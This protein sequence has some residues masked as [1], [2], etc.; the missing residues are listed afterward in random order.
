MV[1]SRQRIFMRGIK[2]DCDL[3]LRTQRNVV[4]LAADAR[5]V[6]RDRGS[7][8]SGMAS[9]PVQSNAGTTVADALDPQIRRFVDELA[10]A[11]ARYPAAD[12]L[13]IPEMRRIAEEIRA[14]WRQGGPAMASTREHLVPTAQGDVRVRIYSPASGAPALPALIYL[15]GGGW[16]MFS[17]NTHDRVMRELAARAG[18]VVVGVDYAL[19]PEAKF[20]FALRQIE[21][22]ARWLAANGGAWSIDT[23]RIAIGGDSAGANLAVATAL[24]L[25]DNGAP[26]LLRGLL[27]HYGCFTNESSE[28]AITGFG[29]PGNLLTSSEMAAFWTNYLANPDDAR[30]PLAAPLRAHLQ[31]LPPA[32]LISAQCD[33]LAEQSIAFAERLRAAGVAVAHNEYPGATHSFL[34]AVSIAAVA[35]RA[36]SDGAAWLCERLGPAA[37]A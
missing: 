5:I 25:R 18:V 32:L 6:R 9:G 4:Q 28:Q 15:H 12:T 36:L 30:D 31:G 13:T 10:Q 1:S 26:D 21:G 34:E 17:L 3:I 27:L 19:S 24:S 37:A 22:V 7:R 35:R 16:T 14:P 11:W 2:C 33:V 20:P 23:A 8:G 29:A